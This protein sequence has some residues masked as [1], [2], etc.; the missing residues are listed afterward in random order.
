MQLRLI[1]FL[2]I[3]VSCVFFSLTQDVHAQSY[4]EAKKKAKIAMN[5][6]DYPAAIPALKELLTFKPDNGKAHEQLAKAISSSSSANEKEMIEY[7]NKLNVSKSKALIPA[8]V[9]YKSA[10]KVNYLVTIYEMIQKLDQ[11]E[12]S[13][14]KYLSKYYEEAKN[15]EK[16]HLYY[17]RAGKYLDLNKNL[18]YN[19]AGLAAM[20]LEHYSDGLEAFENALKNTSKKLEAKNHRIISYNI[21]WATREIRDEPMRAK[22]ME[23]PLKV[24][25]ENMGKNV[26]S[27]GS[28]YFGAVTA[29]ES[30]FLFTS[31]RDGGFKNKNG[32][33]TED[34]WFCLKDSSGN[35][36]KAKNLGSSINSAGHEGLPTLSAD[37][38]SIYFYQSGAKGDGNLY[39]SNIEG[40]D[41]WSKAEK[42]P[43]CEDIYWETQPTISS[44]GNTVFF[45]S[46]R[47]PKNP[48]DADIFYSTRKR[49]GKWK[50]AK[51][52]GKPVNTEYDEGSPF[53]HP[54][55]KTLYFSS[56]G[57]AGVGDYD[58]F[59]T[60]KDEKGKWSEPVNVGYPINTRG[61]D[62]GFFLNALGTRAYYHSEKEGGQG[63]FDFYVV[64]LVPKPK[65][66]PEPI[67]GDTA[68][69]VAMA[70]VVEEEKVAES[71]AASAVTTVIGIITDE[72]TGEP[73]GTTVE[74]Q[75]LTLN[76]RI[77]D[78]KSNSKTGKYV[79]VIPAGNNYA[80]AISKKGYLFHSENFNIPKDNASS[81]ITKNIKLKRI[82]VGKSIVLNN[83]FFQTGSADLSN[84]STLEL[85]RIVDFMEKEKSIKIEISGHTD[86]VGSDA[87]NQSLSERR[88]K[89]VVD[90][91]IGKGIDKVRLVGKGY[92]EALPIADNETD[93]GRQANRRTEFK[94]LAK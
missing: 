87:S 56:Q 32:D 46:R 78:F 22:L 39:Q 47:D 58:I 27:A 38:Q 2:P 79:V 50:K 89:S 67:V 81:I 15:D 69:V 53:I 76:E 64:H 16:T 51:N 83:I 9:K 49:S 6:R 75:N 62:N 68:K 86:N 36:T 23:S 55:G 43:F 65:P 84:E 40:G 63:D 71:V 94:V 57:H 45:I 77:Q 24:E 35:W 31:I 73:I 48:E 33:N 28:D 18:S 74:M 8:S 17:S 61:A 80:I 30:M 52:L 21:Q 88:A 12:A 34:F 44:D 42:L 60:V 7:Y 66:K 85:E 29:D 19:A 92:G 72:A 13:S 25:I 91:L 41:K 10:G 11:K 70:V 3:L 59:K 20:R 93:E 37:G 14:L 1:Y 90:Y 5:K 4:K 26:N 54:D 82:E